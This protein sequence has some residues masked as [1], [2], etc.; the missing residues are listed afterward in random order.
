MWSMTGTAS[1]LKQGG[2]HGR[3]R[4]ILA[5]R[6]M[7]AAAEFILRCNKQAGS[8]SPMHTMAP[9]AVMLLY[10]GVLHR[11]RSF[12]IGVTFQAYSAGRGAEQILGSSCGL[13]RG[14]AFKTIPLTS[15]RMM[16]PANADILMTPEA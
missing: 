12:W 4:H 2:M 16:R 7:A 9:A 13:M 8:S 10:R 15:I 11:S 5:Y 1:T 14:V 6:S 3:R